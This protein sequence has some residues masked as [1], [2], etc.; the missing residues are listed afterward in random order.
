MNKARIY[1]AYEMSYMQIPV[2][3]KFSGRSVLTRPSES[4]LVRNGFLGFMITRVLVS[5]KQAPNAS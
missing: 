1:S 5:K 4:G 3:S 2:A